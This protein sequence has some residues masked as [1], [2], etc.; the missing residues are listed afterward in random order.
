MIGVNIETTA[1]GYSIKSLLFRSKDSSR[2]FEVFVDLDIDPVS[3]NV[4]AT[5]SIDAMSVD[6]LIKQLE[7]ARDLL[8]GKLSL[9]K[10]A[11]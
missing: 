5:G 6:T 11:D 7:I 3:V 9:D 2:R 4:P 8:T 10:G 1:T